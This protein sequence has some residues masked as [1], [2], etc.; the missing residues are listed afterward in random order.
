[1]NRDSRA[2]VGVALV[3]IAGCIVGLLVT[4]AQS[5]QR[6]TAVSL[7]LG[8]TTGCVTSPPAQTPPVATV[9]APAPAV[10]PPTTVAVA[11]APPGASALTAPHPVIPVGQSLRPS[12]SGQVSAGAPPATPRETTP[13]DELATRA[14]GAVT[15]AVQQV[16]SVVAPRTTVAA[17]ALPL[18]NA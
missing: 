3:A 5:R 14:V 13:L 9:P 11:P 7:P 10:A 8:C 12:S 15:D 17:P 4:L 18:V 2:I 16:L 1:V 6:P